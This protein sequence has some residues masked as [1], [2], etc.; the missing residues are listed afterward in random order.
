MIS[1]EQLKSHVRPLQ[2]ELFDCLREHIG[3]EQCPCTDGYGLAGLFRSLTNARRH[4]FEFFKTSPGDRKEVAPIHRE[5][6]VARGPIEQA[7]SKLIF[8]FPDQETQS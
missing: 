3:A 2:V 1:V 7:E 6:D 4:A 8:Q 5:S